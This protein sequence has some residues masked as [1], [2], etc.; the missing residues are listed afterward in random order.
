MVKNKKGGNKAKKKKNKD[1]EE[2]LKQLILKE[3]L[4]FY[5]KITNI[6]GNSR[7][8]VTDINNKIWLGILRGNMKKKVWLHKDDIILCSK[9][10]FQ[11]NKVD[12]FHKYSS[13]E[14]SQLIKI[15]EIT[16]TF[17]IS[18]INEKEYV[19]NDEIIFDDI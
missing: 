2:N 9:R 11:D 8:E 12:I 10:D 3:D 5:G 6:L 13:N 18:D 1:P 19:I 17:T 14:V 7:F 16:S 4:Q 15:K